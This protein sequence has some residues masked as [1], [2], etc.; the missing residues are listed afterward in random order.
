MEQNDNH[1]AF[2][3]ITMRFFIE[4]GEKNVILRSVMPSLSYIKHE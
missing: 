2:E 1:K 4:I 3:A